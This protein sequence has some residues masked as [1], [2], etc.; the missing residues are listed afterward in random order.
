MSET[1]TGPEEP[2]D[3]QQQ[4]GADRGIDDL[5]DN[6]GTER[7]AKLGKEKTGDQC[8]GDADENIADDSKAGAAHDLPGQPTR[9]QADEQ[10]DQNAFI[11]YLHKTP[12]FGRGIS[13]RRVRASLSIFAR[14]DD[15][16]LR[17]FADPIGFAA[18]RR[19]PN[20]SVKR[21]YF[22]AT[23]ALRSAK[24]HRAIRSGPT[25]TLGGSCAV[26]RASAKP[27]R[28]ANEQLA[29]ALSSEGGV[30]GIVSSRWPRL[31]PWTVE[32][33]NPRA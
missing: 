13:P 31:A 23:A 16:N 17:R 11:G 20:I 7:D 24:M 26:Q 32:A 27:Q 18:A 9:H 5:A 12:R 6:A 4:N 29:G 3:Q 2:H 30:P 10:N 14:R 28:G 33:S 25:W 1:A 22:A 8:A 19:K 21:Y 15:S